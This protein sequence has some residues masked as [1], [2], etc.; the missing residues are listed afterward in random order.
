MSVLDKL[1]ERLARLQTE[2]SQLKTQIT[3]FEQNLL[4]LKANAAAYDGAIQ[5]CQ[6]WIQQAANAPQGND[7]PAQEAPAEAA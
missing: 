5:E 4:Q 1:N 2:Q 6:Y 3:A 7:N